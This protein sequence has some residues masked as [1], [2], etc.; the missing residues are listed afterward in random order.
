MFAGPHRFKSRSLF[1]GTAT[2]NMV[3]AYYAAPYAV[4][5][6]KESDI[7]PY[8]AASLSDD[9]SPYAAVSVVT[10]STAEPW[11]A[12]YARGAGKA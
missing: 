8:A 11:Q 5:S 2:P 12:S 10:T 6:Y 7:C 1:A 9:I 4:Q 3:V